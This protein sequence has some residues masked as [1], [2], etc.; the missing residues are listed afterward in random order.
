MKWLLDPKHMYE[1]TETLFKV[2]KPGVFVN[3]FAISMLLGPDPDPHSQYGFGSRTVKY[4]QIH[5]DLDQDPLHW[6]QGPLF[7]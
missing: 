3:F 5:A 1:G 2:R 7:L 6:I 4:L